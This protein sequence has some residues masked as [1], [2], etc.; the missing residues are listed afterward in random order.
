M[1]TSSGFRVEELAELP[2][3]ELRQSGD[4]PEAKPKAGMMNGQTPATLRPHK[5]EPEAGM[6]FLRFNPERL[7]QGIVLQT[8]LGEPRC[9]RRG[10]RQ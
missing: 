8:V 7:I 6:E 5:F 9:R 2:A 3:V 1:K 4:K 10:W